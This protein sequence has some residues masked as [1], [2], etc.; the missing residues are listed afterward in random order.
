MS[1]DLNYLVYISRDDF[2]ILK[3]CKS[4]RSASKHYESAKQKFILGRFVN[5][6]VANPDPGLGAFLTPGSVMG[7]SQHPDPG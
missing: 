6:S 7:E 3:I 5:S 4:S 2:G 1:Q